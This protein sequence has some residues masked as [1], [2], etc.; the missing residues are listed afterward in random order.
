ELPVGSAEIF[1]PCLDPLFALHDFIGEIVRIDVDAYRAD[2]TEIL[3]QNRD[4]RALELARANI[5]LVVQFIFVQELALLQI[6]QQVG[7]AIAQM[8]ASDVIFQHNEGM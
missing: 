1:K 8:P 3:S 2:N 4:G 6:D 7:R 5:Q